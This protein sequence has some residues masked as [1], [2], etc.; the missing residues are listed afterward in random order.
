[1][2]L[3][4]LIDETDR[5]TDSAAALPALLV[6]SPDGRIQFTTVQANLWMRDLF[7][8]ASPQDRLPEELTRWLNN[9]SSGGHPS[10]FILEHPGR[11]LCV[12]LLCR[13]EDSI[14]LLL[15]RSQEVPATLDAPAVF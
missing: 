3:D 15:E 6:V 7:V 11:P 2:T 10:R 8:V 14:S 13:D 4:S 12:F 1:M 5:A 9:E